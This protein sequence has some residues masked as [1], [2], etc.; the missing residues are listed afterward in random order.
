MII[1]QI[2]YGFRRLLKQV[3]IGIDTE[4]QLKESQRLYFN[5]RQVLTK[6]PTPELKN[7]LVK[8]QRALTIRINKMKVRQLIVN[9]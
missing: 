7:Q 6:Q 5:L 2:F 8:T 3:S 9:T 1:L 4:R